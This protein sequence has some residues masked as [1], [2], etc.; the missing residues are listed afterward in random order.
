[1]SGVC[2]HKGWNAEGEKI[3]HQQLKLG[4]HESPLIGSLVILSFVEKRPSQDTNWDLSTNCPIL[5]KAAAF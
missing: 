5:G 3:P 2:C 1:M 4:K